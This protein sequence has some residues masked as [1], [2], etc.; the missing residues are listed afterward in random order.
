MH[1]RSNQNRRNRLRLPIFITLALLAIPPGVTANFIGG[2][3][4]GIG[5]EL[6]LKLDPVFETGVLVKN[7]SQDIETADI[8]IELLG[9]PNPFNLVVPDGFVLLDNTLK[10]NSGLLPGG[11]RLRARMDLGRYGGRASLRQQ[12]IR[13]NSLRLLRADFDSGRWIRAVDA[14]REKRRA[15]IRFLTAVRAD[16]VLGHYGIDPQQDFVWAVLDT[17]GEQFFAIAGLRAVPLPAAGLLFLA[18]S[19]LLLAFS[20]RHQI[21]AQ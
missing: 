18:G 8:G 16:F 9:G 17:S 15:D 3:I 11:R 20:R 2:Q 10:V 12:G 1:R 4:G 14:I 7:L 5:S 19:G 13:I 6:D 21:P